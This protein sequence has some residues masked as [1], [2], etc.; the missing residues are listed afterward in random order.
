MSADAPQDRWAAL[1]EAA[2]EAPFRRDIAPAGL[3]ANPGEAL[4]VSEQYAERIDLLVTDVVMPQMGGADLAQR[5]TAERPGVR[6]VF[7]SG[8]TD[9]AVIRHGVAE[10]G[11]AFLQKPFSL[12]VLA[13]AI[14]ETLDA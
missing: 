10:T 12:G 7:M 6:V 14:R 4:L 8:Y 5:L 11:S 1:V 3:P 9:D 2:A 13:Q